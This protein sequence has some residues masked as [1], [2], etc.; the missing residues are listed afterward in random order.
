MA[1]HHAGYEREDCENAL[2]NA[3]FGCARMIF[4]PASRFVRHL[5]VSAPLQESSRIA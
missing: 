1:E 3:S 5:S 4:G 2:H